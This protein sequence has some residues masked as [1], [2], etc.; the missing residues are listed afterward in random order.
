MD[1]SNNTH[2]HSPEKGEG[3]APQSADVPPL[4]DPV[5]GMT[6]KS[7]GPHRIQHEGREYAFCGKG[8]LEKFKANPQQYVA[9]LDHDLRDTKRERLSSKGPTN[10]VYTCPMHPEV[11]SDRPGAARNA[12]WRS[13]SRYQRRP[14]RHSGRVPCIRR[15]CEMHR[16]AARFAAWRSSRSRPPT[17]RARTQNCATCGGAFGLRPR[18]RSR[19]FYS[20]WVRCPS[21]RRSEISCRCAGECSWNSR[22]RRRSARGRHGRS[23]SVPPS[24]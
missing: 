2:S 12:A 11:R 19:S 21:Q 1:H 5:C 23:S 22:S 14:V 8:W 3:S 4:V 10:A 16:V 17:T 20:P 7:S 6:V 15:S 24:P 18:S 13:N 9:H